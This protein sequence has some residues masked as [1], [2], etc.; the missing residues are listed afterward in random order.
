MR[1]VT[2]PDS[3][4]T[5][6]KFRVLCVDD[7]EFGLF[8]NA[9]I[10]RTEGYD[11]LACSDAVQAAAIANSEELDL[12]ILDYEMPLMNGAE[13]AA[14]CKAANP[15]IKVILYSGSVAMPSWELALADLFV[16]KSDGVQA[17][18]EGVAGL[19]QASNKIEVV[20]PTTAKA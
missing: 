5:K 19:L 8:V 18:L 13:L 2:L 6:Q 7:N 14:V 12:A 1:S 4:Q 3:K 15:D 10:L 20:A 17:L 16:S 9:V 11:V